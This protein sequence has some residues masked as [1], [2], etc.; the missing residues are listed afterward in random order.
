MRFLPPLG[1]TYAS[2]AAFKLDVIERAVPL[3][4]SLTVKSTLPDLMCELACPAKVFSA[5]CTCRVMANKNAEKGCYEVV[6]VE[7][8]HSCSKEDRRRIPVHPG[9]QPAARIKKLKK[10]VPKEERKRMKR[11]RKSEKEQGEK[12]KAARV[13]AKE[14]KDSTAT[15]PESAGQS[16]SIQEEEVPPSAVDSKLTTS[17]GLF[18]QSSI[19]HLPSLP[20]SHS[21]SHFDAFV[22][23]PV[24]RQPLHK[25]SH[26]PA[27]QATF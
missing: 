1:T 21:L 17:G 13:K 22:S 4:M 5:R 2:P 24:P 7:N 15:L 12:K 16:S 14:E 27:F 6:K 20:T 10:E 19:P 8:R 11:I 18:G 23:L 3:G 9:Q 25:S 26:R